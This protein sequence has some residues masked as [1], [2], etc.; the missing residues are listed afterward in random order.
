VSLT[1]TFD[2]FHPQQILY[3]KCIIKSVITAQQWK[4]PFEERPFSITFMPQTFNY[5]DYKTAWYRAFLLQPN[6][7]SWFFNFHEHCTN[8]FPV[9]FF[10]WWT[11]FGCTPVIFP[12]EAKEGWDCWLQS[13]PAMEPYMKEVHFIRQFCVA[14]IFSWEN[15]LQPF[16]PPPYPLSLVRIYK[17]KWWA[18]FKTRLCGKENV[19][20]FCR[21]NKKKFTLHKLHLFETSKAMAP[22]TPIKRKKK[23]QSSSSSAK[24]KARGLSQKE[25]DLLDYLKDDPSMKQIVL[26]KILDKQSHSDDETVSSAASSSPPKPADFQDSQDPYDL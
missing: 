14:W 7:R 4:D 5:N 21:T 25:R 23:E 12:A 20:Y 8:T 10:H 2:K 6:V 26:Q 19:E 17:I 22:A 9:W 13:T 15:R 1:H 24:F 16:L 18:E 3:S 11:M